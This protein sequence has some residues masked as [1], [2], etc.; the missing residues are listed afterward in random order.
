MAT[1]T[2]THRNSMYSTPKAPLEEGELRDS[3]IPNDLLNVEGDPEVEE[4]DRKE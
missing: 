3:E 4:L 2:P 1:W